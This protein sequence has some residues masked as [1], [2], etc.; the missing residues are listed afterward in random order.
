MTATWLIFTIVSLLRHN[1]QPGRIAPRLQRLQVALR[2]RIHAW[3]A[4]LRAAHLL[5]DHLQPAP[6]F[7]QWLG[8]Q[9]ADQHRHV[10]RA[11]QTTPQHGK[12]RQLRKR[13]IQRLR[14][15]HAL[16]PSDQ[17]DFPI[18]TILGICAPEAG[19]LSSWGEMVLGLRMPL[20]P[21]PT[22]PWQLCAQTLTIPHPVKWALLWRLEQFLD[23]GAALAYPLDAVSLRLA[24]Q[25]G[26]PQ[27]L[28]AILEEG[29]GAPLPPELRAGI[30]G[31]PSLQVSQGMLIE[32]SN[33]GE[34]RQVRR[35]E[36]ARPYLERVLSPRHVLVKAQD[37]GRLLC[38]LQRRGIHAHLPTPDEDSPAPKARRTHFTRAPLQPLGVPLPAR[39]FIARA[40]RQQA[41]FE[42]HYLAPNAARSE[43]RHIT[44]LLMEERGGYTYLTAYCHT[45]KG[46]RVFRLDRMEIPGTV[47]A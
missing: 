35:S 18:L 5:T 34:L 25:R 45:R 2:P 4:V 26:E 16:L 19:R 10:L 27:D 24:A 20:T 36:F 6:L 43:T 14:R 29:T 33:P 12:N 44:P 11:W 41:A 23:P 7:Y 37:A 38:L 9:P 30:L 28:I 47:S 21:A 39:E 22:A 3:L 46:N 15:G 8:W 17:R 31:Q 40:I 1:V 42:M 32:F 13:I